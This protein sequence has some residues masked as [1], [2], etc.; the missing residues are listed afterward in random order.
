M[1]DLRNNDEC[2][3]IIKDKL[4]DPPKEWPNTKRPLRG[5]LDETD[6][7]KLKGVNNLLYGTLNIDKFEK[8]Y[9]EVGRDN[10]VKKN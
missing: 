10:S 9:I 5:Y 4:D 7:I 3:H 2:T 1:G 8:E 6:N